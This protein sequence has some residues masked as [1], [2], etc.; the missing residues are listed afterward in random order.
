MFNAIRRIVNLILLFLLIYLFTVP[1]L[2]VKNLCRELDTQCRAAELA[3]Y[4]NE[5][6][7]EHLRS[8]KGRMDDSA[9]TLHLFLD[10]SAVDGLVSAIHA[11][12]PMTEKED[13]LP[14]LEAV[15][16]ELTHLRDIETVDV[17]TLF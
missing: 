13:L 11:L 2:Y 10:H 14:A 12:A 9:K 1:A 8:I 15:R 4:E 17:Y 6:P 3:L 5:D 7:G 16:A